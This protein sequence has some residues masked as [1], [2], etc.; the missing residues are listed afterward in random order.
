MSNHKKE[1][2]TKGGQ[3]TDTRILSEL[4]SYFEQVPGSP[5]MPL[6]EL[7][8][9]TKI[10]RNEMIIHLKSLEKKGWVAYDLT[11]DGTRGSAEITND[12]IK[13]TR[14]Q[15]KCSEDRSSLITDDYEQDLDSTGNSFLSSRE[16]FEESERDGKI[17]RKIE[18]QL[19]LFWRLASSREYPEMSYSYDTMKSY[20]DAL[21]KH[22]FQ[23]AKELRIV[24]HTEEIVD[25]LPGS[26]Q[27][28]STKLSIYIQKLTSCKNDCHNW[29]ITFPRNPRLSE[30]IDTLRKIQLKWKLASS[31]F[32]R[33]SHEEL[34]SEPQT[35]SEYKAN[36]QQ[37][38][39][40]VSRL[41]NLL[42]SIEDLREVPDDTKLNI[43][44]HSSI[45]FSKA[46]HCLDHI[47]ALADDNAETILLPN[48]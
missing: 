10:S 19:C 42:E 30:S 2:N 1:I 47:N 26:L 35:V 44:I 39:T 14:N 45:F 38:E 7:I 43:R 40:S 3:S 17:K 46:P 12:G 34:S 18:E 29:Q 36:Y 41:I 6:A 23:V 9:K 48:E 16:S 11:E 27:A 33:F 8:D 32:F 37:L 20:I 4:Y 31:T 15:I 25:I 13:V 28:M 21:K 5:K 22:L 24:S